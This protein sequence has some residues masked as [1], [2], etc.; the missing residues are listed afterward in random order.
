MI[1]D[2]IT[3]SNI[4]DKGDL[5][6]LENYVFKNGKGFPV[7]YK[8]FVKKYGYGLSCELFIIFIPMKEYGDSFFIRSKEIT[9]TYQ[10][11]I[12]NKE[13]LWFDLGIN[14]KYDKLKDLIPFGTSENGDY[15]FWDI[16]TENNNE[17]DIYITDFRGVAFTKVA[18][19]LYEFFDKITS[20]INFKK[21]L[22]FNENNL[23]KLFKP[24]EQKTLANNS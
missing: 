17:Y 23:P 6:S 10:D 13:E 3:T 1:F 5:E 4:L 9:S 24:L 18:N 2:L 14:V 8:N 12:D 15:V 22:H 21:V 16:S 7:S 19:N 20:N 11:V